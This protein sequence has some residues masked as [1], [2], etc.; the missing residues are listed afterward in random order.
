M[1]RNKQNFTFSVILYN[2]YRP[3]DY[4]GDEY[5]AVGYYVWSNV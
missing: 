4:N 5:I 3:I 2:I 1:L